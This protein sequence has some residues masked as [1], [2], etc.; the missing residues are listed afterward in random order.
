MVVLRLSPK[1]AALVARGLRVARRFFQL[2][3]KRV[4]DEVA[5]AID[6]QLADA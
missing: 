6:H 5:E 1:E 3:H 4:F 2:H